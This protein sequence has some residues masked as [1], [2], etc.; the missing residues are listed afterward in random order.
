MYEKNLY[1]SK[2]IFGTS[3]YESRT[4]IFQCFPIISDVLKEEVNA[5]IR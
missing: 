4:E 3:I 5:R 1:K 2:L